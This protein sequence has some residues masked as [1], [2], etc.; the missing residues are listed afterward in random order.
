MEV[1]APVIGGVA[2]QRFHKVPDSRRERA[3]SAKVVGHLGLAEAQRAP[4]V[5]RP[6]SERE[7]VS[8]ES[9]VVQC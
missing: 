1:E 3:I 7:V 6:S 8:R 4:R 9:F 2:I 5:V